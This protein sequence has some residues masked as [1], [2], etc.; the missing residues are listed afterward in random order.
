SVRGKVDDGIDWAR[1]KERGDARGIASISDHKVGANDRVRIAC[2]QGVEHD[3]L[4]TAVGQQADCV[5][6][7]VSSAAR[8]Q[9]GHP[10]TERLTTINNVASMPHYG[11][12]SSRR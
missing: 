5:R 11:T 9:D 7:H 6:P 3:H 10:A 12:R 2:L 4:V 8:H 1:A